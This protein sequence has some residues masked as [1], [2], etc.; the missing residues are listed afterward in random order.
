MFTLRKIAR[1][2]RYKS[3]TK[4]RLISLNIPHRYSYTKEKKTQKNCIICNLF[5]ESYNFI[6]FYGKIRFYS[7]CLVTNV[8]ATMKDQYYDK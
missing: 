4:T 5:S 3:I 8:T 6:Y 7:D 2:D 1:I